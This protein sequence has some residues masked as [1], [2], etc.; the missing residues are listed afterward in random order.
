[1]ADQTILEP[2][3]L[4]PEIQIGT[5]GADLDLVAKQIQ[6]DVK[7]MARLAD[8]AGYV[9]LRIGLNL[10]IAKDSL[11]HGMYGAWCNRELPDLQDRQARYCKA[12]AE[13]FLQVNNLPA[14]DAARLLEANP[15]KPKKA[16][17][18]LVQL[19]F[20]FLG[21]KSLNE[22]FAERGIKQ[23][24]PRGGKREGAGRPALTPARREEMSRVHWN[25]VNTLLRE[26]MTKGELDPLLLT[27]EEITNLDETLM[28]LRRHLKAALKN[29]RN[30]G[31][32]ACD[33]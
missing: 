30:T 12:L 25:D 29:Q 26:G 21:D 15:E 10:T 27:L 18:E 7:E 2:E 9:A 5:S 31:I 11:P 17:Q 4:A 19:A 33:M 22:I 20:D 13:D 6:T 32:P 1:M 16:D 3:V 8:R 23:R 14:L 28:D 24:K